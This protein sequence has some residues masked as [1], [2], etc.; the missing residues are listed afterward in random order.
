MDTYLVQD[1]QRENS[2]SV[3]KTFLNSLRNSQHHTTPYDHW[4]MDGCLPTDTCEMI[5]ALPFP[6]PQIEDTQGKRDTNNS[7]RTFVS[8][9]LRAQFEGCAALADAFQSPQMI[10]SFEDICG[11]SLV[12]TYLRIEYTQDLGGFWLEPHTDVGAKRFTLMIYLSP[13]PEA[14][15]WG[16]DILDA[17]HNIVRTAPAHYNAGM[18]FVP[19]SKSWHAFHER[20]ITSVRKSLIINYVTTDWR[21]RHELA[22]PE[23]TVQRDAQAAHA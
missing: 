15:N 1:S 14:A 22:F 17:D 18:I 16:T 4:L 6:P 12:G 23:A 10:A 2:M 3:A 5:R 11:A 9:E 21:S 7:V 20:N 13:E 8:P 19:S